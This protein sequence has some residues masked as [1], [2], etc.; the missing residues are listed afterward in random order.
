MVDVL[1]EII[2]A[3]PQKVV[4]EFT[5]NPDNATLWYVNIKTVEWKTAKPLAIGSQIAFVAEFLG[6]KLSYVYEVVDWIPGF[7]FTMRTADGPFP[8]ETTYT[9]TS[10]NDNSTRMTLRNTGNPKGFS[11]IFSPFM[12]TMMRKANNKDLQLL[13]KILES[14]ISVE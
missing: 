12:A 9:W 5:T 3:R 1:T 8:M 4:S 10:I 14:E 13:K 6:K 11:K 7:S 2:I